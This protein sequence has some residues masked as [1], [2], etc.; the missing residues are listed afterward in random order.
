MVVIK[1]ILLKF[2]FISE[3]P[4]LYINS[5]TRF[6]T[7]YGG[8]LGL[9]TMLLVLSAGMNFTYELLSLSQSKI[10]Y[11]Q[12]PSDIASF[13]YSSM[14]WAVMLQDSTFK[15]LEDED[16]NY[17]IVANMWEVTPDASTGIL[18]LQ[19]KISPIAIER[20]DLN[21]HF[22]QYR[23][24][25][26]N[27]PFL[28]HHF[29][30]VPEENN[31]TLYGVYGSI[32]AYSYLDLWISRCNNS[33]R[34]DKRTKCYSKEKIDSNLIQTYISYKFVDFSINHKDNEQPE[35]EYLRSE[36]LSVSTTVYKRNFFSLTNIEYNSDSGLIFKNNLMNKFYQFS[37]SKE[38]VDLRPEGY[39]PGSFAEITIRMDNKVDSYFRSYE[40]AQA[41][42]ANVGGIAEGMIIVAQ[43]LN[44][45]LSKDLYF[46]EL[47]KAIF[48][49]YDV[50]EDSQKKLNMM[51]T[52]KEHNLAGGDSLLY[53]LN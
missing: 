2:D 45:L 15:P 7:I 31:I 13:N 17:Y 30:P 49:E 1:D 18:Q 52:I 34:V 37:E 42:L 32:S 47:V 35:H 16:R 48:K 21:K 26:Q 25:F 5:N 40:K 9:L 29:C 36:S 11:N 4:E 38:Q 22:G 44:F 20:C 10:V 46:L 41:T 43:I 14:P 12:V 6:K 3:K 28:E 23:P 24:L 39:V 53:I 50:Y 27:V 51:R 8:L 33:T 19:T